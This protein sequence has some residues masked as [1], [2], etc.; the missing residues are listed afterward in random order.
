[1]QFT[2][3]GQS[4]FSITVAGKKILFDPFITPNPLAKDIDITQIEADYLVIS[5]GHADH[6]ADGLTLARQTGALVISNWEIH[7][8]FQKNGVHNTHPMNTGG[9]WQFEGFRLKCVVAHHS[10]SLPDGSYGGNPLG[11]I[12]HTIEGAFYYSGDTALTTDMQLIPLWADLK[13]AL[14]PVGNNFTMGV[15]DAL[16]AA[17]FIQCSKVIGVH[18]DTFDFITIDHEASKKEFADAGKELILPVIGATITL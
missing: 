7:E 15:S 1:M 18:F 10:S 9:E 3:Y 4:C 11:F 13:F 16:L 14:L 2:Y 5:H 6:I 12:L 17:G 8:W